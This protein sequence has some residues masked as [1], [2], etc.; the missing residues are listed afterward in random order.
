MIHVAQVR[1][2]G[3]HMLA[4]VFSDG[5]LG[6]ADLSKELGRKAFAP[7]RDEKVFAQAFIQDG[8]VCWPGGLDMAAERLYA[9]AHELT[10]PAT[11]EQA[12]ANQAEV[13][14][15]ELRKALGINQQALAEAMGM[16]QSDVSKLER[17]EDH[18]LSTVRRA[19]HAFGGE[20]EVIAVVGDKRVRLAV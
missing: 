5:T 3:D 19:V 17:R 8:T 14:L 15:R 13:S 20:I 18:L 7:L 11:L 12:R 2:A 4:L 6:V 10:P 1:H 9:L 16:S